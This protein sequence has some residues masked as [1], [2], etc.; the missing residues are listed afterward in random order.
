[1]ILSEIAPVTGDYHVKGKGWV[2]KVINAYDSYEA[3]QEYMEFLHASADFNP[4]VVGK[5]DI[6]VTRD[7]GDRIWRRKFS[8]FIEVEAKVRIPYQS[9]PVIEP[10]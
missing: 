5:V 6:E 8:S 2:G 3:V 7:L 4:E 10:K 9:R 1:M